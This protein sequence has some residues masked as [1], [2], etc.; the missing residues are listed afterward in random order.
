[1]LY[2]RIG[3]K[4]C[5]PISDVKQDGNRVSYKNYKGQYYIGDLANVLK[6]PKLTNRKIEDGTHI[7]EIAQ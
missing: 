3:T 7:F 4:Y 6:N 1:M 2:M 5:E